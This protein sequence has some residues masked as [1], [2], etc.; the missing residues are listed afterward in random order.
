MDSI[1]KYSD[2]WQK[3]LLALQEIQKQFKSIENTTVTVS[4]D[5]WRVLKPLKDVIQDLRSQ[6]VKEVCATLAVMSKITRDS[7]APLVRDL[8]PVLVEVRGGGNKVCGAY[9][10]ECVEVL[11][12]NVVTKGPTLRYLVDGVVESKNKGLRACCIGALTLVLVHWSAVLDKSDVQQIEVGLKS[13]LYDASSTC[14]SASLAFFQRFQ[15][16]FSKRAALLLTT[17][18][19][20]VQRRLESLPLVPDSTPPPPPLHSNSNSVDDGTFDGERPHDSAAADD[21]QILIDDDDE[22]AQ[23]I[24]AADG[25][26]DVGDR[27]C[28]SE[29][30]LFGHVRYIGDV[31]GFS[32]PWV[33]IQLDHADGKND[34][35][36][37]IFLTKR[38]VSFGQED[39]GNDEYAIREEG[40][41]E[42]G[43]GCEEA[44]AEDDTLVAGRRDEGG[45][46]PPLKKLLDSMLDAQRG[47]LD[48]MFLNLNVEMDHLDVFQKSAAI[49]SS[50]DAIAYCDQVR[51]ICQEKVDAVSAFMEKIVEAQQKAMET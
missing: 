23:A 36:I 10:G 35:S 15:Q 19:F 51:N 38:H 50:A 41:D 25:D 17:V 7:M 21:R 27:V 16:K 48:F 9:C 14:R 5:T 39:E 42:S 6:I 46:D 20:K 4:V 26:V 11:V 49:A 47:F 22:N 13:S 32:G 18:D 44:E 1:K 29:K 2:D 33:G 12:S 43:E 30:E 34:G 8:L 45:D 3:R 24:A 31:A 28:I 40:G 37:K